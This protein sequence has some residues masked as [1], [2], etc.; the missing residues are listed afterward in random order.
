MTK[1]VFG[2]CFCGSPGADKGLALVSL[3][4]EFEQQWWCHLEC[5]LHRMSE[6]ARRAAWTETSSLWDEDEDESSDE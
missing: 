4:G 3:D 6:D 2:C 1:I 5:L